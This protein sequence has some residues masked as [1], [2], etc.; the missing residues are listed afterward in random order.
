MTTTQ[1]TTRTRYCNG[2]YRLRAVCGH[3]SDHAET[4][5]ITTAMAEAI[6][7]TARTH[8]HELV[9]LPDLSTLT[10]LVEQMTTSDAAL[11]R[12][13]DAVDIKATAARI[14]DEFGRVAGL[15]GFPNPVEEQC[16]DL[17]ERLTW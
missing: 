14:R 11:D 13:A 3:S 12:A 10:R 4:D 2:C 15:L 16:R 9:D 8:V 1:T 17:I 7:A 6:V 5:A